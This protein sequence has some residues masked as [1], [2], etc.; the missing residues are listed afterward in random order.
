MKSLY[1]LHYPLNVFLF[2]NQAFK[3]DNEALPSSKQKLKLFVWKENFT[4]THLKT[5]FKMVR[6]LYIL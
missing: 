1:L 6:K 5:A 3:I 4:K 2:G